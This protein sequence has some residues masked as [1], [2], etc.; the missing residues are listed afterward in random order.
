MITWNLISI[1]APAK[2]SQWKVNTPLF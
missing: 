1:S 2:F